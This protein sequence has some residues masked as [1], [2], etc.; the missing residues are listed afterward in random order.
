[1]CGRRREERPVGAHLPSGVV[2]RTCQVPFVDEPG[3][4]RVDAF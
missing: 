4:V 2:R 3:G 1:M